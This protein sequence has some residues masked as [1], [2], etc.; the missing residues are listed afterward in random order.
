MSQ[1]LLINNSS[2]IP[3]LFRSLIAF[4]KEFLWVGIFSLFANLL[5]LSPTLYMLQLF[6]RVML[7][8]SELT[9]ISLTLITTGFIVVMGLAEWFRSKLMVRAGMRFDEPLNSRIFLSSFNASLDHSRSNDTN[10]FSALTRLRQFLT[11][12]GIIALFDLPW[13]PIYLSV[14]FVMHPLLGWLGIVFTF[15]L[16]I[17]AFINAKLTSIWLAE[18]TKS[19]GKTL[20]Y[21]AGKLR[22]AE[23]VEA[24]GMMANLRRRWSLLYR[25]YAHIQWQAQDRAGKAGA[26]SKFVQYSQQSIILSLGAWLVIRGEISAGA[27]IASNVLMGNALR[28]ISI[29]VAT[30]K[31]FVHAHQSYKEIGLL[32]DKYPVRTIHYE[33]SKITGQITLKQLSAFAPQR[34]NPILNGINARFEAGE[35]IGVIGPSGAGKSTLIRCIIGIWPNTTGSVQIDNV[36]VSHWSRE[37]LGPRIGY[38]PQE[39]ELLEGS[40]A[41]NICRFGEIDSKAIIDAAKHADIHEM[42]LR[43]PQGYDTPIGQ[44]GK[45]LSGGQRQR[46]ALARAIYGWPSLVVLDEPNANLD[47]A[48]E[49]A[50]V[51][52]INELRAYNSTVFMVLHQRNLLSLADRVLIMS[53]GRIEQLGKLDTLDLP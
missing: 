52:V 3:E 11:G 46:F 42:I 7:S 15:F 30:W 20:T 26:L 21:L 28:P 4:K 23:V 1:T 24:M 41:E 33:A 14:L 29:L 34:E 12:N 53:D 9:L 8:Q 50:L 49:E 27:M 43:L 18:A 48:G 37:S 19:E 47:D 40:V 36:N 51:K 35:I 2:Q 44:A 32:L 38:L 39:I 13:T 5:T 45:L 22:N 6:D 17:L 16:G 25:T 10:P 31:E